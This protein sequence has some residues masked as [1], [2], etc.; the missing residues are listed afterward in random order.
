MYGTFVTLS[1]SRKACASNSWELSQIFFDPSPI[2]VD[3]EE[4]V[5][6]AD[7]LPNPIRLGGSRIV[8]HIQ[9]STEAVDDLLALVRQLAEEKKAAGF[10]YDH[11]PNGRLQNGIYVR[12]VRKQK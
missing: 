7:K 2:G 3:Y 8:V 10:V 4:L 9:T 12:G 6:R 1:I 11:E 5:E